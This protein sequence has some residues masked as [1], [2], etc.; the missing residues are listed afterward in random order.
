MTLSDPW[1]VLPLLALTITTLAV[2]AYLLFRLRVRT[3]VDA[4]DGQ[5]TGERVVNADATPNVEY[6]CYISRNKIDQLYEQVETEALYEITELKSKETSAKAE[7]SIKWG[8]P[9]VVDLFTTGATYG[10]TG[11]IQREAKVKQSYMQ[12]LERVILALASRSPIADAAS[13]VDGTSA[14]S[15]YYH[16]QGAFKVVASPTSH[17]DQVIT[18]K[19][20]LNGVPLLLDCSLRNFSESSP[21]PD[22]RI[23]MNSSNARFF[24]ADLELPMSTLFMLLENGE[25]RIVG[26]PLFLKLS[27]PTSDENVVL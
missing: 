4:D 3:G 25:E 24:S 14:G 19:S 13:L 5:L 2:C 16:F 22:G 26:T 17:D 1:V 15:Q 23:A 9:H 8:V 6:F 21:L 18:I 7:A 12:K 20:D 10:R 11:R 27:V